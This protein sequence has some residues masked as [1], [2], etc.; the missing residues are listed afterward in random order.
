M[1]GWK[2]PAEIKNRQTVTFRNGINS[3]LL[4]QLHFLNDFT[5]PRAMN[6]KP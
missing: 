4:T 5:E 6:L 3:D 2:K 1:V